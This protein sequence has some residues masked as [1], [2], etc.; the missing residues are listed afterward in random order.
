MRSPKES[1]NG[2]V[3]SHAAGRAGNTRLGLTAAGHRLRPD[4]A[5]G[6]AGP[7]GKHGLV[8]QL[9]AA[10]DHSRGSARIADLRKA[11]LVPLPLPHRRHERALRQALDPGIA[12]PCRHC[13]GSC[14][15]YAC[16]KVGQPMANGNGWLPLGTHPAHER[17]PQL[18][19]LPHL[20]SGLPASLR[21]AQPAATAPIWLTAQRSAR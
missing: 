15:S 16:F 13:S 18:R 6:R 9:P 14:S 17:Q 7:S 3:G 2:W 20:R 10:A 5:V 19:A 21:A 4:P 12:G 11:V 1:P 8:E